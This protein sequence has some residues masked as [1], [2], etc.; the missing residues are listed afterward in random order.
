MFL[1]GPETERSAWAKPAR[2]PSPLLGRRLAHAARD[3]PGKSTVGIE[4]R[5]RSTGRFADKYWAR[6]R[7]RVWLTADPITQEGSEILTIENLEING[8]MDRYSGDLLVRLLGNPVIK[9][10]IQTALTTNFRRDY[11]DVVAK[12]RE[13]L[14]SVKVGYARLSFDVDEFS[15]GKVSVTGAGL[16]MPVTARGTVAARVTD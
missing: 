15:Q 3:E 6:S 7:G 12:A 13:G 10:R 5:V 14:A 1:F 9:S 11:D 8:D 2:S 16:F 4:A